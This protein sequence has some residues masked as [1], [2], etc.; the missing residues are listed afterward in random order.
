MV[1]GVVL[2]AGAQPAQAGEVAVAGAGDAVGEE[3]A[4]GQ[5]EF[6]DH[7]DEAGVLVGAVVVG[8]EDDPVVGGDV[9]HDPGQDAAGGVRGEGQRAGGGARRAVEGLGQAPV[10]V[11]PVGGGT[12]RVH[13]LG[14]PLAEALDGIDGLRTAAE[15]Q[16][17]GEHP[18]QHPRCPHPGPPEDGPRAGRPG[19]VGAHPGAGRPPGAGPRPHTCRPRATR[20][21]PGLWHPRATGSS[22]HAKRSQATGTRPGVGRPRATGTRQGAR[23]PCAT[24]ARP[25]VGRPR[26]A[27]GGPGRPWGLG[28]PRAA[29]R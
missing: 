7:V 26:G 6:A 8:E 3:H 20:A 24:G 23:H 16:S 12:G 1:E 14:G 29:H 21:R 22:L 17:R 2:D 13:T 19:A 15:Q 9:V 18:D 27:G 4:E 25:G 28:G 10:A 5:P 11:A